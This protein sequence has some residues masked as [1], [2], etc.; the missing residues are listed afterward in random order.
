MDLYPEQ[1]QSKSDFLS[2]SFLR[3]ALVAYVFI[4]P[5][6]IYNI[7]SGRYLIGSVCCAILAIVGFNAWSIFRHHHYR[8]VVTQFVL[9]P[10]IL[11]LLVLL[12]SNGEMI[13]VFWCYPA[14]GSFHFMLP[15]RRAW[16]ATLVLFG[17]VT[18][19]IWT[20]V[21]LMLTVRVIAT[22]ALVAI[23]AAVFVRVISE[24]QHQLQVQAM[25]DP[26]TGLFNRTLLHQTLDWAIDQSERLELPM[27]LVTL[28]IDH[29]KAVNDTFGHD[30][31]DQVLQGIS[32][33]LISRMRQV[34]QVFRLGGE[35]F[36]VLLHGTDREA[37][38]QV[39]EELRSRVEL[40]ELLPEERAVTVSV[41]VA[42]LQTGEDWSGW[43]KRSDNNLYRAKMGG[44]NRVEV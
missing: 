15:R 16:I 8:I 40:L 26:L 30:V 14:A 27:T 5:F 32:Q 22:L 28:D 36:L 2:N 7:V 11:F 31:G 42:T 24:H 35:E 12:L 34:D 38:R 44:R 37:A 9:I 33:L 25:T 4:T 3:L 17:I 6:A 43:M 10:A 29:F 1:L 21:D 41:G 19:L 13:G 20:F 39:A 23:V 18:P